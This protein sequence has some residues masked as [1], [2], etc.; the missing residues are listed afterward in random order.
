MA[1]NQSGNNS[2]PWGSQGNKKNPFDLDKSLKGVL[3]RFNLSNGKG[4]SNLFLSLFIFLVAFIFWVSS[5]FYTIKEAER[6]VLLR[7]GAYYGIVEPGL[8]WKPNFI[9]DVFPVDVKGTRTQ[10]TKGNMLT[11]DENVVVVEMEVQYR[12]GDPYKYLFSTTDADK[13]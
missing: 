13:S 10:I 4:G 6:G 3:D 2:D 7:F 12:I 5:G 11:Q 9:D 1:W 8:H